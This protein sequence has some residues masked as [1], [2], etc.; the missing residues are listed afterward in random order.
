[1]VAVDEEKITY[2]NENGGMVIMTK[3][4]PFFLLDKTGFGAV[5]NTINSEKMYSMDG[6]H[7]NDDSLDSRT[8][9]ITLLVY[10]KNSKEDNKLQRTLLDVF[11]PKLKGTLTYES[12]G[13]TYEIDV[14]I[15][16]GWDSEFDEKSH[17]NQGTLTFF[18]AN[19]L[20][21]DVSSDSY[22]V[23]MGQTTNLFSFPLAITNDFKFATVD[24]G[25]EVAVTN[26]GHV[27]VGLELNITCTAEVVNPRLYNP[28][29]EEYFAFNNK[30]KGGDTIYLNTNEGKKQVL[31]NGENGFFKR[32][33]GSTFMQI[34]N[35]ETN[36]FILQADSGIENMVANMKYYP[37]LTGVC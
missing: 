13:K 33:L 14:R 5:N 18:A 3:E 22:A 24:V 31:I 2:T 6:E 16:K 36:Y 37:L 15:T 8:P 26:P 29:T 35:L 9:T 17:T 11:N 20:W 27:A 28:Y 12:F 23:Q 4:R 21:R 1:M 30:F 32:K 7:E 34:S 19:P 25:K 10:G